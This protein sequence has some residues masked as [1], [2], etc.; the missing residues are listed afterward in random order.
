[1]KSF[2]VAPARNASGQ[3]FHVVID[4]CTKQ[5]ICRVRMTDKESEKRWAERIAKAMN[6]LM[7]MKG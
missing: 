6:E 4:W 5:V 1:M 3:D 2:Y 7:P